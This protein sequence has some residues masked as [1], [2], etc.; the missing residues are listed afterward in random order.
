MPGDGIDEQR[1]VAV[2]EAIQN[3][4]LAPSAA[5]GKLGNPRSLARRLV[6]GGGAGLAESSFRMISDEMSRAASA[7]TRP[8]QAR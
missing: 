4:R 3:A 2:A 7:H 8:R 5:A 1:G 6:A